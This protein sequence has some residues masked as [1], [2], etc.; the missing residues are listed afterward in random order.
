[1]LRKLR[2]FFYSVA[3][4]V[5]NVDRP[6]ENDEPMFWECEPGRLPHVIRQ[7]KV[8]DFLTI[9]GRVGMVVKVDVED[10]RSTIYLT[11]DPEEQPHPKYV[12]KLQVDSN[13]LFSFTAIEL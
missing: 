13:D 10:D 12:V 3:C 9:N 11:P 7:A 1:M 4:K 5:L 8:N 6:D 2:Q